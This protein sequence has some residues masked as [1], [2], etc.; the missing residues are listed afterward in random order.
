[1]TGGRERMP[2]YFV[3]GTEFE[4]DRVVGEAY[5]RNMRVWPLK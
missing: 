4:A 5:E 3:D 2:L 1:M